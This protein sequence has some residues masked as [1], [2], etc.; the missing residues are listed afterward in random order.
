MD[1]DHFISF[2]NK[3]TYLGTTIT[4]DLD[5]TT[6]IKRRKQAARACFRKL[7]R[8]LLFRRLP[9][10]LRARFY[11]QGP[12]NKLLYGC[13][14]WALRQDHRQQLISF[15]HDCARK[16]LGITRYHHQH[17][18]VTMKSVLEQTGLGTLDSYLDPRITN[19]LSTKVTNPDTLVHKIA[20][21]H[22]DPKK[23]ERG[24]KPLSTRQSWQ[25]LLKKL[26]K[27]LDTKKLKCSDISDS[28]LRLQPDN[29]ET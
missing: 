5:D 20:F 18:G 1:N 29:T 22:A 9:V 3:F 6:E 28:L 7:K 27:D 12:L 2:C 25:T 26:D 8:I 24:R 17:E 23:T 15:H 16:I 4:G 13:E 10:K 14:N 21:A 11:C 19:F